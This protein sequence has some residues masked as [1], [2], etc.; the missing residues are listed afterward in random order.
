MIH[1]IAHTMRQNDRYAV[2]IADFNTEILWPIPRFQTMIKPSFFTLY[3][4]GTMVIVIEVYYTDK[5]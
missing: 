3:C 2:A 5:Y 4:I 1:D